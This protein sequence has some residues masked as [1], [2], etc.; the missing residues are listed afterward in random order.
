MQDKFDPTQPPESSGMSCAVKI[1]LALALGGG[2]SI[3]LCCGGMWYLSTQAFN[4]TED[5]GEIAKIQGEI[6]SI[7]IPA[8]MPPAMGGDMN[9]GMFQMQMAGYGEEQGKF[10]MLMQMQMAGMSKEE[11]EQQFQQQANQ[12][13][14]ENVRITNSETKTLMVDGQPQDFLFAEGMMETQDG[15]VPVHQVSGTFPSRNGHGFLIFIVPEEK[16]DE[17]EAINTVESIRK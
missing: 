6:A 10:L 11:M 7:D 13:Q 4:I 9:F 5:P 14:S 2:L 16:W 17:Q 3:A 12:Q 15:E 8:D 1:V